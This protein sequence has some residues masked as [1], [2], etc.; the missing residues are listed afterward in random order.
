M[1][2][3]VLKRNKTKSGH[4]NKSMPNTEK[5]LW[6]VT[7]P[8]IYKLQFTTMKQRSLLLGHDSE[9]ENERVHEYFTIHV[10]VTNLFELRSTSYA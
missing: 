2:Q 7:T 3:M 5:R 6:H 4:R 9:E 10:Y 1:F 8:A